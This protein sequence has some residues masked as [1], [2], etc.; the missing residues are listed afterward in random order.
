[1]DRAQ[2]H[3]LTEHRWLK[4]ID[5][6]VANIDSVIRPDL[7]EVLTAG[8]NLGDERCALGHEQPH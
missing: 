8:W 6:L 5:C 7:I 2:S 4:I 3:R 1:M